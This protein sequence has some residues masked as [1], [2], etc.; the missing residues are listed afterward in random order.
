V[1]VAVRRRRRGEGRARWLAAAGVDVTVVDDPARVAIMDRFVADHPDL[2][3][4]DV[5]IAPATRP[6]TCGGWRRTAPTR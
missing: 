2:W 5:G 3:Y 1:A 6:R 4:E